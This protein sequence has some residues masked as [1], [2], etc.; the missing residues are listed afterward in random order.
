MGSGAKHTG[1]PAHGVTGAGPPVVLL[2]W[3][4]GEASARPTQRLSAAALILGNALA[5]GTRLFAVSAA[6]PVPIRADRLF[7]LVTVSLAWAA[8][9]PGS[10][11]PVETR[12]LAVGDADPIPVN[13]A[14]RFAPIA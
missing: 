3:R 11:R 13:A 5:A 6:D 2:A 10:A 14:G 9:A 7:A 8:F 1:R 4:A 12:F